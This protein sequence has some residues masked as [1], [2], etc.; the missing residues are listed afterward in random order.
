MSA[1][2]EYNPTFAAKNGR[3]N[4]Q[5]QQNAQGQVTDS[6]AW[7]AATNDQNQYLQIKF[8]QIFQITGVTTQGRSDA[9]QWV[10][11]YKLEYSRDG[12]GW[13][14]YPHVRIASFTCFGSI[15]II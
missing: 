11:K 9:A 12:S 7:A 3:L 4:T 6:G 15:I 8:G 1:S 13:T 14:Y 2:T 5:T 10:K